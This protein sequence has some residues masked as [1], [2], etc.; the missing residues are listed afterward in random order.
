MK[1]LQFCILFVVGWYLL[2][3]VLHYFNQRPLWNDEYCIFCNIHD[4]SVADFF[5]GPL[6][7]L[8]QFPRIYLYLIGQ[9]SKAFHFHLLALRFF[10]FVCMSS[11]FFIWLYLAQKQMQSL[12]GVLTFFMCWAASA[13]LIYYAAELKQYSMDVLCAA[14]FILFLYHQNNIQKKA[15]GF[16]YAVIL[17]FLPL[18]G[19]FSYPVFFF[20]VLPVYNILLDIKSNPRLKMFLAIYLI[21]AISVFGIVYCFDLRVSNLSFL[22]SD[23]HDHM[24]S[25]HSPKEFFKTLGENLDNFMSRWFVQDPKWIRM[26]ARFFVCLGC[27]RLIFGGIKALKRDGCRVCSIHSIAFIVFWEH[28]TM[29]A[30][31]KYPFVVPRT[32]LFFAPMLLFLT[33]DAIQWIKQRNDVVYA[34]VQY[35]FIAYLLYISLGIAGVIFAGDMGALPAIWK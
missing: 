34:L 9:W 5:A 2:L 31:K 16:M 20:M 17:A 28:L 4:R 35:S 25:L 1:K 10:P 22:S 6:T 26:V 11:A 29:G 21:S 8:Q 3:I 15:S 27:V 30:L 7:H 32:S 14:I 12:L 33:V 23:W 19:L 18:L 24:I 13:P